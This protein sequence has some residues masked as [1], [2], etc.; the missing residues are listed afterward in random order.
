VCSG[1][2]ACVLLLFL[3]GPIGFPDSH[4]LRIGAFP[5]SEIVPRGTVVHRRAAAAVVGE[6]AMTEPAPPQVVIAM[7]TY[8]QIW[9]IH[10]PFVWT[11]RCSGYT[12]DIVLLVHPE[13]VEEPTEWLT[14]WLREF[15][16]TT[17]PVE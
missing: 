13:I 10:S 14:N 16:V 7:A 2:G 12:G 11:L 1:V 5:P 4:S 3:Y 17:V 6:E 15:N 9:L 8:G